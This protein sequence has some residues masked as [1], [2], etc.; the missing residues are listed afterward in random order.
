M[1]LRKNECALVINEKG[2][3]R[4]IFLPNNLAKHDCV[5]DG[6]MAVMAILQ[7]SKK[8]NKVFAELINKEIKSMCR[9]AKIKRKA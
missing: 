9:K 1:Y 6:M 7:L 2:E 4:K 3:V 5:S 8:K